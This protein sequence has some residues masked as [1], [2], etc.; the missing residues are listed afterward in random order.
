MGHMKLST[1]ISLTTG[2]VFIYVVATTLP[3]H[4]GLIFMLFLLSQGLLI[5]MVLRILKDKRT[6]VK[7]F[8]NYF[9]EDVDI[10]RNN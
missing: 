9:Y 5:W 7:T 4:F 3:I 6:S 8:D 2:V 1:C 10:R